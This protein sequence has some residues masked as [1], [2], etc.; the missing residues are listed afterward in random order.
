[1]FM[2]S[3]QYLDNKSLQIHKFINIPRF[4]FGFSSSHVLCLKI[5]KTILDSNL[6]PKVMNLAD[7]SYNIQLLVKLKTENK[8]FNISFA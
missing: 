4:L 6:K 5:K 2:K 8:G 7:F 3:H 1:M